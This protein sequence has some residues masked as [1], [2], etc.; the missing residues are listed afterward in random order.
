M[1]KTLSETVKILWYNCF[2]LKKTYVLSN[3]F[4][5]SAVFFIAI[6]ISVSNISPRIIKPQ[7]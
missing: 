1:I 5:C 3:S 7:P 4:W 2:R 6:L